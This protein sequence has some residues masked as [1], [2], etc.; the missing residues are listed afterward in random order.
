MDA[1]A[2]LEPSDPISLVL[3]HIDHREPEIDHAGR[4]V[5]DRLGDATGRHVGIPDGLDLFEPA[6]GYEL[7]EA[8]EQP[9]EQTHDLGGRQSGRERSECDD[10]SEQHGDVR[11]RIRDRPLTSEQ[12][13]RDG[14]REHV[15]QEPVG[16][17]S[18][19]PDR[20]RLAGDDDVLVEDAAA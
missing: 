12:A 6:L 1:D 4:V 20:V 17:V 7:I 13:P 8:R 11:V 3:G 9:V 2:Q 16:S 10:V 18:L 14:G 5:A 19:G 15:P